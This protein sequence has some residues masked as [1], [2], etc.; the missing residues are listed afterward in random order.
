MIGGENATC[1]KCHTEKMPPEKMP[2]GMNGKW[3][4]WKM[5]RMSNGK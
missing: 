4:E 1:R 2:H 3:K 5:K